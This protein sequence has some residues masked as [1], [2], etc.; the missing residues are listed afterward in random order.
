M[1]NQV[2]QDIPGQAVAY[3]SGALCAICQSPISDSD[4]QASCPECNAIYHEDCWEENQGCAIYGCAR[5]PDTEHLE[6]VE[7]PVSYWGQENKPCPEC[8]D[9]I[10]AAAVRCRHCGT[11]FSSAEPIDA[12]EYRLRKARQDQFPVLRKKIIMLLIF[13]LFPLSAPVAGITGFFWYMSERRNIAAMPVL[14]TG[15]CKVA[16]GTAIGQTVLIFCIV[17][18]QSSF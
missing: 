17:V 5:T 4:T 13:C 1:E 12:E 2:T 9:E 10:L 6:S 16:I 18:L 8:G 15:L 7:I 14:Y 3:E 11:V